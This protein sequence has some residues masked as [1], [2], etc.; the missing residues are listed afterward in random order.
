[1]VI[2]QHY[3]ETHM[4]LHIG[5]YYRPATFNCMEKAGDR[6]RAM[7]KARGLSQ[8]DL[9]ARLGVDQ[10]TVSDIER[11]AGFS[12]EVLMKLAEH[13][14]TSAALIMHGHDEAV[15][16]FRRVDLTDFL[17]LSPEQRAYVEGRLQSAIEDAPTREKSHQVLAN[18]KHDL[19]TRQSPKR[20]RDAG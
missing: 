18:A 5:N 4:G 20:R 3:G 15:W 6:I 12:A 1:M 2:P 11:G 8:V 17:A 7:R 13:L 9:A 10:S 19:E 16:P 14:E